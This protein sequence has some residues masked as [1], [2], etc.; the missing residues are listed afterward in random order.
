[1][2]GLIAGNFLWL[3]CVCL[4]KRLQVGGRPRA[5]TLARKGR[6]T[7][8]SKVEANLEEDQLEKEAEK[9]P[10]V[11]R[12]RGGASSKEALKE[13]QVVLPSS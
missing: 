4:K 5:N 8:R 7:R 9:K 6:V 12:K 3:T 1:M 10:A 11:S 13:R 2:W